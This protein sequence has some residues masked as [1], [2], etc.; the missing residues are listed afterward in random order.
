MRI[1]IVS[2]LPLCGRMP[3]FAKEFKPGQGERT[4]PGPGGDH[5]VKFWAETTGSR[6]ESA[7]AKQECIMNTRFVDPF[8]WNPRGR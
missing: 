7:V 8:D 3:W 1:G 5:I 2:P 6:R 4:S